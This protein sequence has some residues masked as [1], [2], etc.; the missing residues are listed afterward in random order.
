MTK[1]ILLSLLVIS[2]LSSQ[3]RAQ[4]RQISGKVTSKEDG[5]AMPGVNILVQGTTRG[6][7]TD[8]DGVYS[9]EADAA[10]NLVFSF[11]GYTSVTLPIGN[12]TTMDIVLEYDVTSLSEVVVVGYGTQRKV[13]VTGAIVQVQGSEI[14]R[15]PNINPISS[16]QG[17]IA[18]VQI[19]NSGE[20]GKSPEIRIRGTG[21]VYGNPNPLYVVDGVWYDD[22][23][24]LN[25]D[26]IESMS[27]L[28]DASSQAIY[29][30]RA[31]NGVLLITTKK[32]SRDKALV[33]TY[34]GYV[35]SQVVTNQIKMAN[36][37]QFATITNELDIINGGATRYANPDSFGSTDWY[38]Q[39][40]RAAPITNHQASVS[41]G[42]SKSTFN[43]S[44]GYLSQDGI[45]SKNSFDRYTVRLQ[46]DFQ[47]FEF[48]KMGYTMTGAVNNSQ[49]ID[50]AIFRQL[51]TAAPIVPV[52]Y[53]DGTYGDPNDFRVGNSNNFNPQ[54][55]IDFYNQKSRN[56]RMTG[57][58][59]AEAQFLKN[60]KFRSSLGGDF[61][62]QEIRNYTPLY[63]ATLAQRTTVSKLTI[64]DKSDRNWIV[65][66]T[67][68][69][70]KTFLKN[71]SL[72]VLVGQAAQ[73][74]RFKKVVSSAQN[75]PN[76]SEGDYYLSLGT[77]RLVE[78]FDPNEPPQFNTVASYFGRVNYSF[79][80]KYLLTA[81]MRA[82]GSSKFADDNRW[83]YFPSIGVGWVIS[84]EAFMQNQNIVTNLK[85][86]GSWGKIGNV[87]VPANLS[88]LT[89]TQSP[90]FIYVGGNGTIA[91]GANI[92]SIVPPTTYW[93]RGV[94]TDIGLEA[95]FIRNKLSLEIDYYN[96]RTEL[97]IFDIP[98]LGSLGT[99]G[100]NIRGNQA[101]FENQG[102]E[103]LIRWNDNLN[104][105]LSYSIN[106]N[107]GINNNK[108]LE[109]ST[110]A[111]P[112]FQ[113]VG[114]TGS[115][116][117]NTRTIVGE[118]IGQF[119]GLRVVGIFQSPQDIASYT[120]SAGQVI[121]STA[122]PGDFKY[123]DVNADGV[124]D[125]KDRVV[126]GNPNPKY[127]YGINTNWKYKS[128]DLTL[129]FQGVEG[130]EIYNANLSNRFGTEN[131]T[132]DFFKNRWNGEGSSNT[133]PSANIGGGQN[134][135]SNSFFVE[136]GAYF[137]VRNIQLG[138]VLPNALTGK[139]KISQVRVYANA[140]NALNLF[141]YR[142][143]SPEIGGRPTR[144]GVDNNVYPL[145]ATYNVGLNVTF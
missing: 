99:G 74:Y 83:G 135:R 90:Q 71:H 116:N 66:N 36:G 27:V 137:R 73:S 111:N 6:T 133:Y 45:V 102:F 115:N 109:V 67:L 75:V 39:I 20:P 49:D 54:V 8:A 87:S 62:Q 78:D 69:Y 97:A 58:F 81:S 1:A 23:S 127:L 130:V 5:T 134:Y 143:F 110:G 38:R 59:Y 112:I 84:E 86:R 138:Y 125:D 108:V 61:A 144:A 132:E 22:I 128:L 55:T 57:S 82:D 145:F 117:F 7:T 120:S 14:A 94:G 29:G 9:I 105:K 64:T 42:S 3:V 113:A 51:Y 44:L 124:I 131:F 136:N 50:G 53:A 103:F 43:F 126:L 35:G 34:S 19:T 37:P 100:G 85:L 68:T 114:T 140:Q 122:N 123:A 118:P 52:Y 104:E 98:I 121:Q 13:D 48:L 76:N 32:G 119:Y 93:E 46:N 101:T 33:V 89:I 63:T 129:D 139:W 12:Q 142:G 28:K 107:L 56:Y 60:F 15:Q 65:E 92:N 41:G 77:N 106:A 91:P 31:A 80:E 2:L 26:D 24:F 21:T 95:N 16:L 72:S 4:S 88:V 47:P 25:P 10:N 17:K 40:L 96:K 141:S 18:G 30:V 70:D 11:I 79:K